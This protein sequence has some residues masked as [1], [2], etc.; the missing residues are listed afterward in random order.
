MEVVNLIILSIVLDDVKQ[1]IQFKL[2]FFI[3]SVKLFSR[4]HRKITRYSSSS[5]FLSKVMGNSQTKIQIELSKLFFV[6]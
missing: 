3:K 4:K 2:L 6:Q 1:N 5:L